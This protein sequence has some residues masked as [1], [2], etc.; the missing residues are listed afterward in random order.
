MNHWNFERILRLQDFSWEHAC[1][2][3]SKHHSAP[4]LARA[5]GLLHWFMKINTVHKC[6]REDFRVGYRAAW[7]LFLY[8]R[9][10]VHMK[11]EIAKC[12]HNY[13]P[14]ISLN[15]VDKNSSPKFFTAIPV[16]VKNLL[17][18]WSQIMQENPLNLSILISG[19]KETN[20]DSLSK[21]D[22]SGKS[23][24]CESVFRH[25]IVVYRFLH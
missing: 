14:V 18:L 20:K 15:G 21:G 12:W 17:H 10:S 24:R 23:S 9:F 1:L 3:V 13:F 25:W 6:K 8:V 16:V 22:W 11:I 4:L 5:A 2:S 19:G 7:F